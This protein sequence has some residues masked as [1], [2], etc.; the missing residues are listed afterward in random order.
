[1]V[2]GDAPVAHK[3]RQK[4]GQWEASASGSAEPI[5][6]HE[7]AAPKKKFRQHNLDAS[8]ILTTNRNGI[9]LCSNFNSGRCD[10]V[11]SGTQMMCGQDATRIHQ[12][13]KCLS[14]HHGAN[15]C[16]A[17]GP[18]TLKPPKGKGKGKRH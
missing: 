17:T 3:S 16:P 10:K 14:P 8:G 2:D 5:P 6:R 7:K 13:A 1:M 12:C 15:V 4:Q 9:T 11:A 18:K